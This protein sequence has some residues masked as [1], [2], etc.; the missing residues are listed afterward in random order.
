MANLM[1]LPVELKLDIFGMIDS[2]HDLHAISMTCWDF[3]NIRTSTFGKRAAQSALERETAAKITPT[4]AAL[5]S[6]RTWKSGK[7]FRQLLDLKY[8]DDQNGQQAS[9]VEEP[10]ISGLIQI[11]RTTSWLTRRFFEHQFSQREETK[12]SLS[13]CPSAQELI[14]VE[15]AFYMLWLWIEASYEPLYRDSDKAQEQITAALRIGRGSRAV[16]HRE[17][18]HPATILAVYT[19]LVSQLE[20]VGPIYIKRF[21]ARYVAGLARWCRCFTQYLGIA[22]PNLILINQGLDGVAKLL[23]GSID[24]QLNVV[25]R[26][27]L[28]GYCRN[29]AWDRT[30]HSDGIA[31]FY[32]LLGFY[33]YRYGAS[34]SYGLRAKPLWKVPGK[35]YQSIY[36]SRS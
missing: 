36:A 20:H 18:P 12:N 23:E 11:R 16:T 33:C 10:E 15:D 24:D 17:P 3:Q 30:G 6:L 32:R 26:Q 9:S 25:A 21:T 29:K 28:I 22:I 31:I 4:L 35:T 1:K 7:T 19:F 8:P 34:P 13:N 2:T 27:Y 14:V 5:G